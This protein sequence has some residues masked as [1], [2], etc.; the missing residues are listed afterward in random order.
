MAPT[1][2]TRARRQSSFNTSSIVAVSHCGRTVSLVELYRTDWCNSSSVQESTVD[3]DALLAAVRAGAPRP[4]RQPGQP[5]PCGAMRGPA[6][7]L[8]GGLPMPQFANMLTLIMADANGPS[9]RDDAWI[10][11]DK[12]GL[13]GRFAFTLTCPPERMPDT[14]PPPGIPPIVQMV[15]RSSPR[16]RSNSASSSS[17]AEAGWR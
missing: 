12:T 4:E 17:R 8:A 16:C 5:P 14:Q 2:A 11:I 9:G 10:V 3:C 15:R 13:S 7:V 1:H 6:R